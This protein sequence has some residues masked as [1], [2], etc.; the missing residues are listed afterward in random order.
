MTESVHD[1]DPGLVPAQAMTV[2][3]PVDVGD[4]GL[5][6]MHEHLLHDGTGHP[7]WFL[8]S[9]DHATEFVAET[10]V[11]MEILGYLQRSPFICRDN[12]RLVRSDPVVNE[13]VTFR[14]AG[15]STLVE[16]TNRGMSPDPEGLA[17]ISRKAA[18]NVIAGCGFYVDHTIATWVRPRS[19]DD[20]TAQIL[21]ELL[22]GIAGT[23]IR[24]GVIGEVG[25][26]ATITP[27]EKKS[28]R[29]A[30]QASA[31]TGATIMVHLDMAGQQA[32][33]VFR[34]LT[35]EGVSPDRIVMNHMDE[36]NDL[37][38]S[39]RVA[40]LGCVVQYDT[41]GS[42]W[43]YDAWKTWEPR[44]TERVRHV[45]TLCADGLA[46]HVTLSQDVYYKQSLQA[47]GGFGYGHIIRSIIPMLL[48][49]GVTAEQIDTMLVANPRRLLSFPGGGR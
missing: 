37:T 46:S 47:F 34:V 7:C 31:S 27:A 5:T 13:L 12:T 36:A 4:L 10:P 14:A 45:A 44:D 9:A 23:R 42:E 24:A 3:G 1:R 26:S 43:Y 8:P 48:D 35:S 41:F 11:T 40:E 29:A 38:Y 22:D 32:F 15:G 28:L 25:T 17:D 20:L 19:V 33:E 2:L 16:L 21:G 39:R 30:G 6:L 49:A 18:V